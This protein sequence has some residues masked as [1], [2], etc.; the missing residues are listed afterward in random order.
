MDWWDWVC[1]LATHKQDRLHVTA[2]KTKSDRQDKT[3]RHS[4]YCH[5]TCPTSH[6]RTGRQ[7]S[8]VKQ[9]L[10]MDAVGF[11]GCNRSLRFALRLV[12]VRLL[13]G[14]LHLPRT[15]FT[16]CYLC[17]AGSRCRRHYHHTGYRTHTAA[18][19][20]AAFIPLLHCRRALP[21]LPRL[22]TARA[23]YLPHAPFYARMPHTCLPVGLPPLPVI[24]PY[25]A[26]TCSY[27]HCYRIT[28]C[29]WTYLHV[30]RWFWTLRCVG[31]C[32]HGTVRW[33][34]MII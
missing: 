32:S 1:S 18:I 28:R 24:C 9:Q 6:E 11:P 27:L 30:G 19:R 26:T 29:G 10:G 25:V 17:V 22:F 21:S 20:Y 23:L 12:I 31:R 2:F 3:G 14:P 34:M 13:F 33:M 5:H 4:P 8:M 16:R 7:A 15:P